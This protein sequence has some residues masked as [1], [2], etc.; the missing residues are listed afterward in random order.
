MN[1]H[2]LIAYLLITG[3]LLAPINIFAAEGQVDGVAIDAV[4]NFP[5]PSTHQLRL[6]LD[7][8][9]FNPYYHSLGV[10]ASYA[11]T[12]TESFEWEVLRGLYAF[13]FDKGLTS[14]LADTFSVNP[15]TINRLEYIISSSVA[16]TPIQG[17]MIVLHDLLRYFRF[18][19]LGGPSYI[20]T[21]DSNRMGAHL[22]ARLSLQINHQFSVGVEARDHLS[23]PKLGNFFTF[24]LQTGF[25]F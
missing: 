15:K 21:S 20:K 8:Y 16:F 3:T 11:Y 10:V 24:G 19:I 4:E 13:N 7:L 23:F 2:R 1:T 14:E 25:S 12:F 5:V 6:G 22:G 18:S 9:P 17:K